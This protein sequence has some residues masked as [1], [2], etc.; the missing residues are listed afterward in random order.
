MY[1]ASDAAL[2]ARTVSKSASIELS[3]LSSPSSLPKT[4]ANM[5]EESAG[6]YTNTSPT[7]GQD[8]LRSASGRR[9]ASENSATVAVSEA[10]AGKNRIEILIIL[11]GGPTGESGE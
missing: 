5:G 6:R 11:S 3:L 1:S 7:H 9:E 8:S 4:D 2:R 10:D